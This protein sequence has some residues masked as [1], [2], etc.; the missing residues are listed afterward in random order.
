[1]IVYILIEG[2]REPTDM[3]S[4][5]FTGS[6]NVRR[7]NTWSYKADEI[8]QSV[9]DELPLEIQ[10]E[11]RTWLRPQKRANIVKRGSSI[12]HYFSPNKL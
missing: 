4:E 2:V 7:T 9:I 5:N 1:M 11:F 8:D 3:V 10:E 12:A 6:Q